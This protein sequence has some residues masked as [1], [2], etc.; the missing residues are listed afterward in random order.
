MSEV[1]RASVKPW[2]GFSNPRFVLLVA[3][4]FDGIEVGGFNGGVGAEDDADEGA[5]EEAKNGPV[6]GD[7]G[8]HFEEIGSD[9]AGGDAY[10]DADDAADF[11]EDDGFEDE[12]CHDVALFGADGA[13][14]ANL[15]GALGDGDEHDVHDADAGSEEGDGT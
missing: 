5:D 4:G 10:D 3:E 7:F 13:A 8:G 14:D 6:D 11:A 1:A 9:I 2:H 15:A 12:L